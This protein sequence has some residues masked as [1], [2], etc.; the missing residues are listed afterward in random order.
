[1]RTEMK[2]LFDSYNRTSQSVSS[3]IRVYV[4]LLYYRNTECLMH[5]LKCM[6]GTGVMGLPMAYKNGGLWVTN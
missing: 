5:L 1:M 6:I 4:T 2:A 3:K